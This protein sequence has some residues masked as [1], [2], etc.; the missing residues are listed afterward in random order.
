MAIQ[1]DQEVPIGAVDVIA[2]GSYLALR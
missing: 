1:L 2:Y